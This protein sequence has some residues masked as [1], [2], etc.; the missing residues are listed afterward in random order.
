MAR[1]EGPNDVL[2]CAT[3]RRA[4]DL[5]I[6]EFA[7]RAFYE[8]GRCKRQNDGPSVRRLVGLVQPSHLGLQ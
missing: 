4:A 6:G 1:V 8:T 5:P 3:V 2:P 7:L